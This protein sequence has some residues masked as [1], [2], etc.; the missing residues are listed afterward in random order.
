M[1]PT[2]NRTVLNPIREGFVV[3]HRSPVLPTRHLPTICPGSPIIQ[4]RIQAPRTVMPVERFRAPLAQ[5]VMYTPGPGYRSVGGHAN[6]QTVVPNTCGPAINRPPRSY[7]VTLPAF[8]QS[9]N[10]SGIQMP[11]RSFFSSAPVVPPA[12]VAMPSVDV[13]ERRKVLGGSSPNGEWL[14]ESLSVPAGIRAALE[15]LAPGGRG[16]Q[17]TRYVLEPVA[18]GSYSTM[19]GSLQPILAPAVKLWIDLCRYYDKRRVENN[20]RRFLEN[21]EEWWNERE[22][23]GV[24]LDLGILYDKYILAEV[25]AA[26]DGGLYE[27]VFRKRISGLGLWPAELALGDKQEIFTAIVVQTARV[28]RECSKSHRIP[29]RMTK[30]QFVERML[31]VPYN[32]PDY[33]VPSDKLA[34]KLP[35][36]EVAN[37]LAEAILEADLKDYDAAG[38]GVSYTGKAVLRDFTACGLVSSEELQS[39]LLA[40]SGRSERRRWPLKGSTDDKLMVP[41]EVVEDALMKIIKKTIYLLPE[42]KSR[43][44]SPSPPHQALPLSPRVSIGSSPNASPAATAN[45]LPPAF[46]PYRRVT[47]ED[48]CSRPSTTTMEP[49]FEPP[50]TMPAQTRCIGVEG[51]A[52]MEAYRRFRQGKMDADKPPSK[53][54]AFLPRTI[55]DNILSLDGASIE[56][57]KVVRVRLGWARPGATVAHAVSGVKRARAR[58]LVCKSARHAMPKVAATVARI[59][60]QAARNFSNAAPRAA[61]ANAGPGKCPTLRECHNRQDKARHRYRSHVVLDW[62]SWRM[63]I[64]DSS[65]PR[66]SSVRA[67]DVAGGIEKVNLGDS[68]ANG[69]E[70]WQEDGRESP[71]LENELDIVVLELHNECKGPFVL[72]VLAKCCREYIKMQSRM[73]YEKA[74]MYAQLISEFYM[75]ARKCM[76]ELLQSGGPAGGGGASGPAVGGDSDLTNFRMRTKEGTEIIAVSGSEYIL[77]VQES[78]GSGQRVRGAEMLQQGGARWHYDHAVVFDILIS[79]GFSL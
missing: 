38:V 30:R 53:S 13:W 72:S 31:D 76:R 1:P 8:D 70:R 59:V 58:Y 57:V 4:P 36:G 19:G 14:D 29:T 73:P 75:K 2:Y 11:S 35:T 23:V 20:L 52:R 77:V 63:P 39:L 49:E 44:R 68:V 42:W 37:K 48:E 5:S 62:S 18:E 32:V 64:A 67:A 17:L 71:G 24:A 78:H 6:S 43:N 16:N 61:A 26:V 60:L 56:I 69:S 50:S 47:R 55:G 79:V 28:L 41:L 22:G 3:Q 21:L 9:L 66:N 15:R 25:D 54:Q 12:T 65:P 27:P 46:L 34:D 7:H 74:V 33:P 45:R 40:S 10:T 51:P